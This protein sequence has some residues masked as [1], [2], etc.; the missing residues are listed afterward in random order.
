[1]CV[2]SLV[3]VLLLFVCLCICVFV[4]LCVS[5]PTS[6]CEKFSV[7]LAVPVPVPLPVPALA[8]LRADFAN[9]YAWLDV[10]FIR[11]PP[12]CSKRFAICCVVVGCSVVYLAK[13]WASLLS[14]FRI[15]FAIIKWTAEAA[16][17]PASSGQ[18]PVWEGG[19][20]ISFVRRNY[21]PHI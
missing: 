7:A 6:D 5:M 20:G 10:G 2:C 21:V 1:M 11:N 3:F 14:S 13:C 9:I 18:W 15:P 19:E 8:S 16:S 12:P 17:V 4:C